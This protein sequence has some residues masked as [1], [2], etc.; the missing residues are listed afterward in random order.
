MPQNFIG[1]LKN[2]KAFQF[3]QDGCIKYYSSYLVP[4]FVGEKKIMKNC[5]L[6]YKINHA[7]IDVSK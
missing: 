7:S 6:Y 3:T 1:Y 2:S 5:A 4:D